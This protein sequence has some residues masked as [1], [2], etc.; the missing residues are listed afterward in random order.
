MIKSALFCWLFA[1]TGIV[2]ANPTDELSDWRASC[3]QATPLAQI[4]ARS[5]SGDVTNDDFEIKLRWRDGE[6]Q[7]LALPEAWYTRMEN[8]RGS[9]CQGVAVYPLQ[10]GQQLLLVLSFDGR[11]RLDRFHVILLDSKTHAV[12]DQQL[13]LGELAPRFHYRWLSNKLQLRM[14]KASK[15]ISDGPDDL[16]LGWRE[17][18]VKQN[19]IVLS[20][21]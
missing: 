1:S 20:W 10:Q 5:K 11:P 9:L 12:L 7:Q 8:W 13:D 14:V 3:Q 16:I 6:V 21:R 18:S 17:V 4:E 15:G 19:K 2:F